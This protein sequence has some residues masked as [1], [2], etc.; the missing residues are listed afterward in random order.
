M[1]RGFIDQRRAEG[2][3]V[4]S[5][6]RVLREQ[7]VQIAARTS[8]PWRSRPA[9]TGTVTDATV[10]DTV[11]EAAWANMTTPDGRGGSRLTPEGLHGRRR[12]TALARRRLPDAAW[13]AVDRAMRS[14]D[15]SGARRDKTV[16][17]TM[18]MP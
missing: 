16:R 1:V 8:R 13:G 17:T 4:E 14:P 11:R 15:P 3:V 10:T 7:G 6:C 18:T 5:I 12:M 9:A 2:L